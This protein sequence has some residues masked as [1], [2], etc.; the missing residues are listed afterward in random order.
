MYL[1]W[2]RILVLLIVLAVTANLSAQSHS[3]MN[4]YL[5]SGVSFPSS[6]DLFSSGWSNGFNFGA[7]LGKMVSP[8]IE[9]GGNFSFHTFSFDEDG[10]L[11]SLGFGNAGSSLTVDGGSATILTAY[12]NVKLRFQ[13]APDQKVS[14]YFSGGAGFFRIS[15]GDATISGS[16]GTISTPGGSESALGIDFGA[17]IDFQLGPKTALFIDGKYAIGFTE[18]ESVQYFPVIVG[19]RIH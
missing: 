8:A 2:H 12:G 10:L 6:P 5:N 19:I 13:S 14:P 4:I 16:G 18:D 9:L 1:Q 3:T 11:E 15:L 7:G 17:G